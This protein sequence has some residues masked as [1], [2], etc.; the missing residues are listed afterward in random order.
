MKSLTA[1]EIRESFLKYFEEKGHT[2]VKS[3]SIIPETDP[4]LLF[5]NAGMVPFKNVFL[6]LEKRPYKRATSC[7][8]VFRVSGKHNDLDNVGYTPR[9]HTFFEMLGNFSFGDYFKREAIEFAWE[10]LTKV[11]EIPEE[12]LLVSVFEEDD[13]AYEI[14]NKVIGL[15]EEK[16]HRLGVEDNFWS[17]GETGPCGP[18]SEIYYDRGEKFGNPQLG[19]PDDNRYL[20]VWNLVF[21]QY[22]RDE[23]GKLTPL[24]HPN[25][26]TGMGLERIASVL[27]RVSSNYET[28]LFMPIIRFAEDISGKEYN[29]EDPQSIET[30]SMRVI[31]DHLRA[32]T[33]LISDGV[34][35]ANE[36]R[37]YVLRRILRR[38]LRYGKEI[39]IEKPFLFEGVDVVIDIF[40]EPYPELIGNRGFIK[41]LVKAEEEKFIKTLKRGMDILYEIIEKAKKEGRHHITGKEVFMLYDTYGFPVDLIED[42]AKDNNFGVD[43]ADYYELLEEQ[44]KRARASWKSQ[45]K[46]V[47]EI[48]IK[49]KNFLPENQ[50]VGYEKLEVEDAKILAVIK[51]EKIVG[52]LREGET[53][54]VILD[55][56]PFY[57]E[58]GG[59]VGDTG[60]IE[61]DGFLFEVTDTKTPVEGIIIHKGK[62]LF[63]VLKEGETVLGKV[64]KERRLD[65]MR[66]HTATH[67]LHAAL[68]SILG[69]HVKQA[70]SLVHPDYLRFDFTHFE[71]LTD[72]DIKR[73][74][75]LVNQEIMAN[76]PVV[77]REMNIDEALKSGAIA[78]FEEKYGETVRVIS[79][80]ISTELCG[81]THVSRTGDIGYFKIISESAVGSGTRRIEA[82][83]GRKAVKKGLK[84]HFLIKE[85]MHTLT[86]KEDQ[87]IDKIESLKLKVK[88]LERELESIKKKS[89]V[90]R[91]TEILSVEDREDYKVA[92][93]KIE[94]LSP[95]ELR[96][97]ADVARAKLG[98]SVVLL[99]SVDKEK[100]KINLI[101]AVSKELTDKIK[102][103]EVIR[104]VAPVIGGKGGGRP[105]MAQGGGTDIQKLE[106][107]FR[108]F[109]ELV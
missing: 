33:F 29:P 103:G 26:D 40:K 94:N 76:H 108:K 25:I 84:E 12:R 74:E 10:Y 2:R 86:S 24:P 97:L 106:D 9:H 78:I 43:I 19:A 69:E 7:Q 35:P 83:A 46:E 79:A 67:L 34:F 4:T 109:L 82:V 14:W 96:D 18:C 51:D 32:I 95:N 70:G 64:D 90:E 58:K 20:E 91:I 101:V 50:F 42:I 53:G 88:E 30:V 66:H 47:K 73:I 36:G 22:N 17:M 54:E 56:T 89:V 62:V 11:L 37:G 80:G 85:I 16:I 77:C 102:A 8:K 31:A 81:G 55:I 49:L 45:A 21:M 52:E 3:A 48:Y 28:D 98:K 72:E 59:Q 104:Q 92:Y 23:K 107:A 93:G 1:N 44:R 38:A 87:I 71:A 68:R 61:G 39:G 41:G 5:V 105:D 6:G 100:G 60:V 63:G 57:P 99:A 27:Q 75:E 13:E 15:P 65:T